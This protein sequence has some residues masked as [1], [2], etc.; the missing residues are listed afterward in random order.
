MKKLIAIFILLSLISFGTKTFAFTKEEALAVN[1]TEKSGYSAKQL[2]EGLKDELVF[3]SE[4]FIA[5]EQKHGVNAVFL[6]AVAALES[7]WGKICFRENNIFGWNGK[8]FSSKSECIDFVAEKLAEHYLC[9]EGK[10][11]NG[12][13]VAGVNV[14]YNGNS[15]WEEKIADIMA[16]ISK[17]CGKPKEPE[18]KELSAVM[19]FSLG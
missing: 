3:L 5:A 8:S 18:E 11:Y 7:G 17:K 16:M 9:E 13:T 14:C 19:V 6:A 4:D 2:E 1:L 12:K 15:F 10:Y